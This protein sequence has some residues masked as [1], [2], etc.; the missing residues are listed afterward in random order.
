[1]IRSAIDRAVEGLAE[2]GKIV[3][4]FWMAT[5]PVRYIINA[6]G[7]DALLTIDLEKRLLIHENT[8]IIPLEQY[9]TAARVRSII[10]GYIRQ[11]E[12]DL[13][14][15]AKEKREREQGKLL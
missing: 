1:M 13:E 15:E 5:P 9:I 11:K 7:T 3:A 6:A 2:E 8:G 14:R 12:E 10:L 4:V